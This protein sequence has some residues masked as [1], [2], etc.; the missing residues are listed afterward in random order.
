MTFTD[1]NVQ[2]KVGNVNMLTLAESTTDT[3]TF[4]ADTIDIGNA[5]I[6]GS[7]TSSGSFGKMVVGGTFANSGSTVFKVQ[8]QQGT[9]FSIVDEMSGSI[10]SAN[11]QAGI[12]VIEAFSD[13]KVVLGPASNPITINSSG[14]IT[15][16]A[17]TTASFG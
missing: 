5:V 13:Q 3:A 9:L 2:F 1:D 4:V 15:S 14:H 8:G 16:S 11:T 17:A 10:F 7:L 6:S 12:P